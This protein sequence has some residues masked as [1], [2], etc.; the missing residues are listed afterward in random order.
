MYKDDPSVTE[1]V[2]SR[3]DKNSTAN[4]PFATQRVGLYICARF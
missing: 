3:F 2:Y 1:S 4:L